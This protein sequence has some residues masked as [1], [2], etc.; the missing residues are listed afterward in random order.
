MSSHRQYAVATPPAVEPISL[1][2][3]KDHLRIDGD[4]ED[5]LLGRL[6]KAARQ[7]IEQTTSRAMISTGMTLRL[8]LSLIHI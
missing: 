8:R 3:A 2:E 7:R 1:D 5:A 6:I 4:V